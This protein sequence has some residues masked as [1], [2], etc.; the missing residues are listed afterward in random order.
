MLTLRT[1]TGL[2]AA[3][4]NCEVVSTMCENVAYFHTFKVCQP[5]TQNIYAAVKFGKILPRLGGQSLL[6][7]ASYFNVRV[8]VVQDEALHCR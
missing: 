6:P 3:C 4:K 8:E 5:P 7:I 2:D 1:F